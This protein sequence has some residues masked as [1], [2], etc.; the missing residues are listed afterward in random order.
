MRVNDQRTVKTD[1]QNA[2]DIKQED[3]RKGVNMR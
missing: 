3:S 2:Q 1:E